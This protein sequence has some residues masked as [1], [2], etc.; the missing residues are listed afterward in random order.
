MKNLSKV[1][2]TAAV[3]GLLLAGPAGLALAAESPAPATPSH[4]AL[5]ESAQLT[6]LIT[7]KPAASIT[8][9]DQ[10]GA[11]DTK[12]LPWISFGFPFP[13]GSIAASPMLTAADGS[14]WRMI[15]LAPCGTPSA[16]YIPDSVVTSDTPR[17]AD[18]PVESMRPGTAA[19]ADPAI[20]AYQKE[21]TGTGRLAPYASVFYSPDDR[22]PLYV[23][24]SDGLT[25]PMTPAY[26]VGG[27]RW[28]RIIAPGMTAAVVKADEVT[29]FTPT[30][31]DSAA[32]PFATAPDAPTVASVR[33]AAIYSQLKRAAYLAIDDARARATETVEA[34]MGPAGIAMLVGGS[35]VAV[36]VVAGVAVAGFKGR[37]KASK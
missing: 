28:H 20:N 29:G 16:F 24:A 8:V 34:G 7:L 17:P 23:M 25:V 18:A 2:A 37:K 6:R 30:T 5:S 14:T 11:T 33:D 4:T 12:G 36:A 21:F 13:Q 15:S 9:S 19:A 27:E 10:L 31:C 22:E 32:Q 3:T 35:A 26:E 1:V